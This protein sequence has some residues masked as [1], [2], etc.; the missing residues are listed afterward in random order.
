V[1]EL[2]ARLLEAR[3]H[4]LEV[5]SL[6]MGLSTELVDPR[7]RFPGLPHDEKGRGLV[8]QLREG[9]R[10]SHAEPPDVLGDRL[11][12]RYVAE[13]LLHQAVF[14]DVLF[15]HRDRISNVLDLPVETL[16]FRTE[17]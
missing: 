15:Q 2:V 11:E 3:H 17:R 6:E 14:V 9:L 10:P 1:V 8:G 12:V 7:Q 16:V 13:L 4:F 5:G